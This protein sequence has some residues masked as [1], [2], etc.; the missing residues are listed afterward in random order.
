MVLT[1]LV[2]LATLNYP[3]QTTL[4]LTDVIPDFPSTSVTTLSY[5]QVSSP[6][7][8]DSQ[9]FVPKALFSFCAHFLVSPT[10]L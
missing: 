10:I 9:G 5:L 3:F 8:I 7:T 2:L 6:L 4:P 1:L